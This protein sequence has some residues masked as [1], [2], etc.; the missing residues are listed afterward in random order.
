MCKRGRGGVVR[1][2]VGRRGPQQ[3][4]HPGR[5]PTTS[6][7]NLHFVIAR[8]GALRFA[9]IP[10]RADTNDKSKAEHGMMESGSLLF[11]VL[12]LLSLLEFALRDGH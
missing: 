11:S 7:P 1:C 10:T 2:C 5:K 8:Q 3:I 9:S 6:A 4:S 12:A